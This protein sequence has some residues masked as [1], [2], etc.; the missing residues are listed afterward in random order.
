[1][2]ISTVIQQKSGV[3]AKYRQTKEQRLSK[4]QQN[5]TDTREIVKVFIDDEVANNIKH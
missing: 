1:M 3:M 4:N 5:S 2:P